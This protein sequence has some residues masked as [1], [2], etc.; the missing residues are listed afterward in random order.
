MT[1]DIWERGYSVHLSSFYGWDP[2]SWG[3]VSYSDP[4]RR[5]TVVRDTT[6]P[7]ITVIYVTKTAPND[8]PDERGMIVGFYLVSHEEGH[9]DAFTASHQHDRDPEKWQHGLRALR[10]FRFL[11]EY[12]ISIDDFDPSVATKAQS[13]ARFGMEV[14]TEA[15]QR[16]MAIPYVEE[17]IFGGA[18]E[19]DNNVHFPADPSFDHSK[20]NERASGAKGRVGSGAINRSGYFVPAEPLDAPKELYVLC[21]DGDVEA[22]LGEPAKGRAIFKIGYSMSPATRRDAFQRALPNGLY[23]WRL[24]RST[25]SEGGDRYPGSKAAIAGEDA[26]KNFLA[27]NADW[28]SG[29][30]YAAT[31]AQIAKAWKIGR[32]AAQKWLKE[33]A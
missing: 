33:N 26:M 27:K 14:S 5:D 25:C 6:N 20:S 2:E 9:R 7:F 10:A 17:P 32:E 1:V 11:P 30:F 15:A 28:L 24:D 8:D 3:M 19:I 18:S 23:A 12:R 22:W 21:L 16:L 13:V 29:E 4:G 31:D